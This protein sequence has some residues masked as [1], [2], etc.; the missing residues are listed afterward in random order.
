MTAPVEHYF[1]AEESRLCYFEWGDP[2]EPVI[3][4]LHATGF[5]ARCWDKVIENLPANHRII[6]AMDAASNR[7]RSSIG[8]RP[9]IRCSR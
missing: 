3:L 7:K 9:P 2:A 4:L 6:A 8:A 1:G 5:H